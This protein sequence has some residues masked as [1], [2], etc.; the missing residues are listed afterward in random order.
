VSNCLRAIQFRKTQVKL[1]TAAECLLQRNSKKMLLKQPHRE[2]ATRRV[3]IASM[4]ASLLS[5][6][7][8]REEEIAAQ[9]RQ[10]AYE[11]QLEMCREQFDKDPLVPIL[12]G[13]HL[14]ARRFDFGATPVLSEDG[15]C[16]TDGFEASFFWT[17]EKILPTGKRFTGLPPTLIPQSWQRLNVVARSG[18]R[19]F[20]NSNP[21]KCRS[22]IGAPPKDW[23]SDLIVHLKNYELDIRLPRMPE[24]V[25]SHSVGFLLRGWPRP[26]GA[27]RFVD[28]DIGRDFN[29]FTRKEIEALNFGQITYHCQ[30]DFWDFNFKG[31]AARVSMTAAILP[32]VTPSLQALQK[33]ISDSIIQEEQE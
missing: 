15:H 25:Q 6:G 33:Y 13:G 31:G 22:P 10:L 27:P 20:C 28:C 5:S 7:C 18:N 9:Q 21:E 2:S 16:G 12:G 4:A 19:K 14:D 23:P 26:D 17:G 3:F 32:T 30:A 8:S 29:K 24:T 1:R 11:K